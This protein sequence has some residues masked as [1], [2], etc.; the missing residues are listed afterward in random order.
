VHGELLQILG[1]ALLRENYRARQHE[2]VAS[3]IQQQRRLYEAI[4]TNTPDLAY[5]FDLSHRFT[6]ANKGHS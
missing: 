3:V 5:I 6:Y 2:R 1:D 4:L